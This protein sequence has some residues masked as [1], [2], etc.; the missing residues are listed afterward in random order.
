MFVSLSVGCLQWLSRCKLQQL[1]VSLYSDTEN[2]FFGVRG[3][4]EFYIKE[5]C[6]HV[7]NSDI[8]LA[9]GSKNII[10]YSVLQQTFPLQ[11]L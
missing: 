11:K 1:L 8:Q 6:N 7:V 3:S 5:I 10:S 2:M 9:K 4:F